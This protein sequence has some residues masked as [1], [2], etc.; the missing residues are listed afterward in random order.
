[1]KQNL[2]IE[3]ELKIEFKEIVFLNNS[4]TCKI[5]F[6]DC[7][8]QLIEEKIIMSLIYILYNNFI[9]NQYLNLIFNDYMCQNVV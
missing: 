1:L 2:K 5:S 9:N 8:F 7:S 6:K 3:T 4:I